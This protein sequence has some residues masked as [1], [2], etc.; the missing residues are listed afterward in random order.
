MKKRVLS[1][2]LGVILCILS[3]CASETI[4]L[5]VSDYLLEIND[6][7]ASDFGVLTVTD[8][9]DADTTVTKISDRLYLTL[10]ADPITGY[11]R[12]AELALY[13]E[14][15]MEELDYASFSYFFLVMLKAYD[16]DITVGNINAIHNALQIE[17]YLPGT[18]NMIGY[19]SCNYY[20]QVTDE[21]A[22]FS[23]DFIVTEETAAA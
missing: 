19:G 2:V 9:L 7:A 10:A 6:L 3:S 11:V 14:P 22:L 18:D 17:T 12:R 4:L 21:M 5:S 16:E 20:Y 8:K 15:D 23:A 1:L 13:L